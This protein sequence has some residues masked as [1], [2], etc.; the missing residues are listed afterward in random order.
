MNKLI[1]YADGAS[2]GNPGPAGI[3]VVIA[4]DDDTVLEEISENIGQ[5][6]NNAAEYTA[7][8]KALERAQALGAAELDI[9]VDSE[10]VERQL[11]GAY[12]VKS[13]NLRPLRDKVLRLMNGFD[14][15][16][17]SH[18]RRCHNARADRLAKQAAAKESPTG[19]PPSEANIE[20]AA[21]RNA[22]SQLNFE[23]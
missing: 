20:S 1:I 18:V 4:A 6:T 10:L 14:K 13:P 8:I 5:Q 7:L 19:D 9:Y 16:S 22:T 21:N 23:L 2:R 3:G 11:S 17:I 12:K 15:V